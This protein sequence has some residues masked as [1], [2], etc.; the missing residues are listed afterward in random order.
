[1][2]LDTPMRSLPNCNS[3]H[4]TVMVMSKRACCI[5]T[6]HNYYL[7]FFFDL[8]TPFVCLCL[9]ACYK[10]T[11]RSQEIGNVPKKYIRKCP[12]R[13]SFPAEGK[14]WKKFLMQWYKSVRV[15]QKS[16]IQNSV[17]KVWET[18]RISGTYPKMSSKISQNGSKQRGS[19]QRNSL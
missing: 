14:M 17:R 1:M 15:I 7:I 10:R 2:H 5:N 19:Y 6:I 8:S 18:P 9:C 4:K 11:N 13:A 16:H 12:V 3:C